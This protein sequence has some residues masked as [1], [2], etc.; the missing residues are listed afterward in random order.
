[1]GMFDTV[2]AKIK[3]HVPENPRDP[4]FQSKTT[5]AQW[6]HTYRLQKGKPLSEGM[7]LPVQMWG[8]PFTGCFSFYDGG[9]ME[10]GDR[11]FFAVFHQG[12]LKFLMDDEGNVREL[13]EEA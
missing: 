11:E 4:D 5:P 6:M 1:M 7:G 9:G 2:R 13:E 8:K 3:G 12:M 10:H